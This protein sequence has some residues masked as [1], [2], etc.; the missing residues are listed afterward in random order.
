MEV[1]RLGLAPISAKTDLARQLADNMAKMVNLQA[2]VAANMMA[3]AVK[4]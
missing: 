3:D 4:L 1:L 2:A